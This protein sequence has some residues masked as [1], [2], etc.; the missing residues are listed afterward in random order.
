MRHAISNRTGRVSK[1]PRLKMFKT[2]TLRLV[3]LEALPLLATRAINPILHLTNHCQT[4]HCQMT[5]TLS[6]PFHQT[7]LPH[8]MTSPCQVLLQQDTTNKQLQ[9]LVLTFV[10]SCCCCSA[11][12]LALASCTVS[13]V[14]LQSWHWV[15]S[16][17]TRSGVGGGCCTV[18]PTGLNTL[19][20]KFKVMLVQQHT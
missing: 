14:L 15:V 1:R 19:H 9:L 7:F 20:L 11:L 5:I 18:T 13:R 17:E 6:L 8:E 16:W 2:A 4:N 12:S 10:V 3:Q